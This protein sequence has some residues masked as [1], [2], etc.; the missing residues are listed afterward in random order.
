MHTN[1]PHKI[2][3][4]AI[5]KPIIILKHLNISEKVNYVKLMIL[6]IYLTFIW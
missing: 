2:E 6:Y 5:N 1:I 4:I 3:N